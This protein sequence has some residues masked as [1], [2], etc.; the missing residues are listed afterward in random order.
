MLIQ[1]NQRE[2]TTADVLN[3]VQ[4]HQP[5]ARHKR[6]LKRYYLGEHDILRKVGRTNTDVNNKLVANYPAYITNMCTGFFIG[7][8]VTYRTTSEHEA[9]LG[10]VHTIE[11]RKIN[12]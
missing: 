12:E 11:L 4:R 6:R 1:T 8:P 3:V 10:C 5:D 7:Q 2:L 9:E